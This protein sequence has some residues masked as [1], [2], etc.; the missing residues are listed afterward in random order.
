MIVDLGVEGYYAFYVSF[1][2]CFGI[3]RKTEIEDQRFIVELCEQ[4]KQVLESAYRSI[5][6]E[7]NSSSTYPRTMSSQYPLAA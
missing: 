5:S 1:E 4:K 7:S 6:Q 2:G 3:R